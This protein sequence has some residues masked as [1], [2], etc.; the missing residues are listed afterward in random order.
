MPHLSIPALYRSLYTFALQSIDDEC[1]SRVTNLVWLMFGM[2][3]ARSV[4]LNLIARKL[5]IR[6]KKL[7]LAQRLARFL[8]NKAVRV[9]EWYA[10]NARALLRQAARSGQIRLIIDATKVSSGH[11]LLMVSVAFRRRSLPLAWTWVRSSK[12]HSTTAKQVKLLAYVHDV[13]P[14]GVAVSLVGDC[15][16]DHPLLIE[17]LCHWQWSYVLRQAKHY[18][19]WSQTATDWQRIDSLPLLKGETRF[20]EHVLLT[21]A[22]PYPV[23]LVLYWQAGQAAPWFLATNLTTPRAALRAYRRRM[24]IEEMFGDFKK[25]GLDLE[26]THLRHFLRLSRLTL[27]ACLLY[28]WLMALGEHVLVYGLASQ[29]D[30]TD[31][32]DLSIFRLGWDFLEDCLRFLDPIPIVSIPNF[33][34]VSAR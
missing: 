30:R 19:V 26:M 29:V 9:R 24:W 32:R 27:A 13:L 15:E 10:P 33:C 8:S 16:F 22:S 6:A 3:Q 12:G 17:N 28:L 34:S 1:D 4:Q 20:Y 7:S 5:P 23:H 2:F 18:L 31:R 25:H 21:A 14:S 11:R